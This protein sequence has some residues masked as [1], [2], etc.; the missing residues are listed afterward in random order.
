MSS[1][2]AVLAVVVM[3]GRWE[4]LDQLVLL[5]TKDRG[6]ALAPIRPSNFHETAKHSRG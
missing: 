3:D 4:G 1:K 5:G 6:I 2:L